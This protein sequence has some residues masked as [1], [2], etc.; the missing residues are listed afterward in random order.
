MAVGYTNEELKKIAAGHGDKVSDVQLGRWHRFGLLPEPR[1][2]SLGKGHGTEKA[3]YPPGAAD[4]LLRLLELRKEKH[5]RRHLYLAWYLWWDHYDVPIG[6]VREFLES[7]A[8][9]WDENWAKLKEKTPAE[10]RALLKKEADPKKRVSGD[11]K[12]LNPLRRRVGRGEFAEFAATLLSSVLP[13]TDVELD[14]EHIAVGHGFKSLFDKLVLDKKLLSKNDAE[15][16]L[17]AVRGALSAPFSRRL[18]LLSDDELCLGRDLLQMIFA[19]AHGF[20]VVLQ[21]LAGEKTARNLINVFLLAKAKSQALWLLIVTTVLAEKLLTEPSEGALAVAS[22]QPLLE[23]FKL[24][25]NEVPMLTEDGTLA[26]RRL[27][28]ALRGKGEMDRLLSEVQ[29]I[30]KYDPQEFEQFL[31]NHPEY[32]PLLY[33]QKSTGKQ[34]T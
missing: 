11:E 24:L 31:V 6:L 15:G 21:Q 33:P 25:M 2:R 32:Q 29:A 4:Q 16:L 8:R 26:T 22:A 9:Q 30:A 34:P 17:S 1:R 28:A 23:L 27:N 20:E 10:L 13:D 5:E 12:L 19:A 18:G 3:L 14:V 7:V